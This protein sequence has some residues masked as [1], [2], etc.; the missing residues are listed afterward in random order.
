M[1][2]DGLRL[3]AIPAPGAAAAVAVIRDGPSRLA[4]AA[5]VVSLAA[6]MPSDAAL[7]GTVPAA[8]AILPEAAPLAMHSS[9]CRPVH[10]GQP[11]G[12]VEGPALPTFSD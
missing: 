9:G 11:I 12:R 1:A 8:A 3:R 4:A 2:E 10:T 7:A 6:A 5:A